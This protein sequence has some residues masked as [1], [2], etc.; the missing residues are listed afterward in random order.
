MEM[1]RS[2][3]L[4][5][6]YCSSS[7]FFMIMNPAAVNIHVHLFLCPCVF[8]SPGKMCKSGIARLNGKFI[9]NFLR[10]YPVACH[11]DFFAFRI[12]NFHQ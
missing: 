12:L 6:G 9:F 11:G 3:Y 10:N 8:I 7:H 5:D 1:L 4:V 2:V